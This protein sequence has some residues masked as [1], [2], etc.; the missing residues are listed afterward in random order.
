MSSKSLFQNYYVSFIDDYSK[1]LSTNLR[2]SNVFMSS[3][4]LLSVCLIERSLQSKLTGGGEYQKLSPF[5]PKSWH[6]PSCVVPTHP[7]AKLH[8]LFRRSSL[9][10]MVTSLTLWQPLNAGVLWVLCSISRLLDPISRLRSTKCANF[11][12]HQGRLIG[13]R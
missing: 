11:F 7:P 13:Q 12:M 10:M 5:F 4:S 9:Y 1:F 3:K 6:Y 8:C 2:F